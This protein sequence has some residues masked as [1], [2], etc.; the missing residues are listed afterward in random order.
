MKVA[1][2]QMSVQGEKNKNIEKA[3]YFIDQA[4]QKGADV[5]LLPECFNFFGVSSEIINEAE[6]IPGPTSEILSK[7][8]KEHDIYINC[9]SIY[10]KANDEFAYNTS[11]LFNREGNIIAKY[12]KIHLY[13]ANFK[14]RFSS[15]ES[16][17]IKPGEKIVSTE[18]EFGKIGLS[19]CYDL[20]FPELFRT[21][22]LEGSQIIFVPAAFPQYTGSLY[23]ETL[24]KAR[25]VENQCY[26][27]SAGQFGK[28][29]DG[30][31]FFG[32]SLIVD[33]W[34]TQLAKAQE[35]EGVTVQEIDLSYIE[36]VR[37]NIP[38]FS[39]RK[40]QTYNL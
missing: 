22:A 31:V 35:K 13:D 27:V 6:T 5:V 4:A 39:H 17:L 34:G 32:N 30:R 38:V 36:Q 1:V 26:I 25:A 40:P 20:R 28:A 12:Q 21:L 18:T 19:I 9:G 3:M 15:Y 11:L 23:W 14:N 33:P 37:N 16:E 7:K 8:A 24:L 10:E 29:S 2:V